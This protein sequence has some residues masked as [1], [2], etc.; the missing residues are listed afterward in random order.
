M[1]KGRGEIRGQNSRDGFFMGNFKFILGWFPNEMEISAFIYIRD[2]KKGEE[3]RYIV[4][5]FFFFVEKIC[6]R[7]TSAQEE[8]GKGA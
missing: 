2:E 5:F 4:F 6:F 7:E 3:K 1:K 8:Q